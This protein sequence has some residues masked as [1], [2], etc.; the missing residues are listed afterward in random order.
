MQ[1]SKPPTTVNNMPKK[2]LNKGLNKRPIKF[3]NSSNPP[4][5][6]SLKAG[7]T[8]PNYNQAFS[9]YQQSNQISNS[10]STPHNNNAQLG[11]ASFKSAA[12]QYNQ[13][14]PYKRKSP[15]LTDTWFV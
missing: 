11:Q 5:L 2:L 13:Y 15:G 9:Q 4:T 8:F 14:G 10:Y 12:I 1:N 3:V 6:A 7:L